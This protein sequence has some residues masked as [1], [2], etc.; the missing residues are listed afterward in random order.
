MVEGPV[1]LGHDED[2]IDDADIGRAASAA[3][4]SAPTSSTTSAGSTAAGTG[5]SAS[6]TGRGRGTCCAAATNEGNEKESNDNQYNRAE[7]VRHG[8]GFS[9]FYF[10]QQTL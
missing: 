8:A 4:S 2:V 10:V 5:A 7:P 3:G 9:D 6:V 1:F